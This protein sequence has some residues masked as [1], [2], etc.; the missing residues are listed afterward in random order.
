[1]ENNIFLFFVLNDFRIFKEIG[2]SKFFEMI[3]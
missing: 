3:E 2:G 1:M